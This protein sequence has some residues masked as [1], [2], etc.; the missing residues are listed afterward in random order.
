MSGEGGDGL[1][2]PPE[3]YRVR[4][5]EDNKFL[6]RGMTLTHVKDLSPEQR[7]NLLDEIRR[8]EEQQGFGWKKIRE[9]L[10]KRSIYVPE[11]TI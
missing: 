5:T 10:T 4:I 6:C 7:N 1:R 3:F 2:G 8:L 9:E 11:A